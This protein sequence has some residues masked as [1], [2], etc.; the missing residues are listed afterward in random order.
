MKPLELSDI[1]AITDSREQTPWDLSPMR[2]IPGTLSVGDYSIAGMESVIAIE[3]KSLADFVMCCGS[4]RERFQRE[5]DRL[6]GWPVS[7]VVIEAGWGDFELAQWRS[8]LTGK[9]VQ[10]SFASWIAQGHRMILGRDASTSASI[11]RGI[12]FYAVRYRLREADAI[13]KLLPHG[14]EP[15]T[16]SQRIA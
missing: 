13:F 3:R 7:A 14:L 11:A 2:S 4:E 8:R 10:A 9:Q 16:K 15:K 6:R 1:T 12:L 5:L